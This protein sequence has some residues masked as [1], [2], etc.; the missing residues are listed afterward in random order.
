MA[1][2]RKQYVAKTLAGAQA[3][4]RQLSKI[5]EKYEEIATRL[6]KERDA[7][8]LIAAAVQI[9]AASFYP[10]TGEFRFHGLLYG[11][12]SQD[13]ATIVAIIGRDKLVKAVEACRG[14]VDFSL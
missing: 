1:T 4:V 2:K 12:K 13:W 11:A 6:R 14:E 7:A 5:T 9:G 3:R 10:P 8:R